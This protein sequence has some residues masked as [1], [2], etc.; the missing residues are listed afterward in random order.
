MPQGRGRA[1]EMTGTWAIGNTKPKCN[2]QY[3]VSIFSFSL[4]YLK[5]DWNKLALI[6]ETIFYIILTFSLK[7]WSKGNVEWD[8][9]LPLILS[10]S[11]PEVALLLTAG[12]REKEIYSWKEK[13]QGSIFGAGT[14][15]KAP[16]LKCRRTLI[17]L[18]N[19]AREKPQFLLCKMGFMGQIFFFFLVFVVSGM[20]C[21]ARDSPLLCF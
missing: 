20:V 6:P 10:V 3:L 17:S 1:E 4:I 12:S 2:T 18:C 7:H 15:S 14:V 8:I 21:T 11:V 5:P 16:Y 13:R 19:F 9:A